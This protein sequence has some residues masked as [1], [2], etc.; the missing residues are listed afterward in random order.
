MQY[1]ENTWKKLTTVDEFAIMEAVLENAS[2]YLHE[3]QHLV[4]VFQTGTEISVSATCKFLQKQEFSRK[5]LT[6]QALQRSEE[7][8]A[9]Y[10]S[11]M[12]LYEQQTLVFV[13]ETGSDKRCVLRRYGY[14]LKGKR[15]IS[16]RL[17]VEGKRYSTI[18]G[19]RM[20]GILDVHITTGSVDGD[21]FYEYVERC[22][23]AF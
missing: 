3:L 16:E 9:Q 23:N 14:A 21:I 11:E 2:M 8:R 7:L 6:Y 20:D 17:L 10:T 15:A 12:S 4:F 13:D 19:M 5:R 18:A 1:P 22:L